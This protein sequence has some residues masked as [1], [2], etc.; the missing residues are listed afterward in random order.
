MSNFKSWKVKR[1]AL[2]NLKISISKK[3][4]P[5][6]GL[7]SQ[8][9]GHFWTTEKIAGQLRHG[10]GATS[11]SWDHRD[12]TRTERSELKYPV[13]F[14]PSSLQSPASARSPNL[15]KTRAESLENCS[16][17]G[18]AS[19]EW[20]EQGASQEMDLRTNRQVKTKSLLLTFH[21]QRL[22]TGPHWEARGAGKC[23]P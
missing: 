11:Q 10:R 12:V 9:T 21:W 4:L 18:Q 8:L 17:Q 1:G 16:W 5:P 13:F 7:K 15:A 14:L 3:S 19:T 20:V 22:V 23:S 2:S 6:P